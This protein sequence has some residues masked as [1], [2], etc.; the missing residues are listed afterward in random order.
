MLDILMGDIIEWL[1]VLAEEMECQTPE[2]VL[3]DKESILE[4]IL[5][6][7]QERIFVIKLVRQQNLG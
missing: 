1:P 2:P 7:D 5:Y 3:A 6:I 4:R